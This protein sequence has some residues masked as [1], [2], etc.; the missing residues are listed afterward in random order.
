ML[1]ILVY[2]TNSIIIIEKD[3]FL[4]MYIFQQIFK[5]KK[6]LFPCR[7]RNT[8]WRKRKE[9]KSHQNPI[10]SKYILGSHLLVCLVGG[11]E[12]NEKVKGDC[13]FHYLNERKWKQESNRKENPST[14]GPE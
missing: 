5:K 11:K 1:D 3:G 7:W 6:F 9:K 10:P 4:N 8:R 12:E 2:G 14:V 13:K